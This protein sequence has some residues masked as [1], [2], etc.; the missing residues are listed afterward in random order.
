M[1][2]FKLGKGK[3]VLGSQYRNGRTFLTIQKTKI[4]RPLGSRVLD[5]EGKPDV[6]IEVINE[7][8]LNVLQEMVDRTREQLTMDEEILQNYVK[9]I[10]N[11]GE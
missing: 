11:I 7:E 9:F 8:G 1:K 5:N 4:K 6:V 3:V 10:Y 2:K